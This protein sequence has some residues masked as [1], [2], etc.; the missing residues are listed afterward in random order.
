M[1]A[2]RAHVDSHLLGVLP[3]S[4]TAAWMTEH[5]WTKCGGCNRLLGANATSGWHRKCWADQQRARCG[6]AEE[7]N[8]ETE[9]LH[10]ELNAQDVDSL[11][12]ME[13][14]SLAAIRT[15]EH[16]PTEIA[17]TVETE[18]RRLVANVVLYNRPDAWEDGTMQDDAVQ[19]SRA[20]AKTAWL[21]LWMFPKTCLMEPQK[22]GSGHR[23]Q[24]RMICTLQNR[25]ERWQAGERSSLWEEA[26]TE[27]QDRMGQSSTKKRSD[28][29]IEKGKQ[30]QALKY[31]AMGMPAKAVRSLT[32]I[33]MAPADAHTEA[34]M[35]AKFPA[36]EAL[37]ADYELDSAPQSN[38]VTGEAVRNAVASMARGTA[39][40]PS[41]LRPDVIKQMLEKGSS[42]NTLGVMT[43]FVNLLLD[44]RAPRA[45]APWLAG[46][47]GYAFQKR[48]KRTAQD[49]GA[50]EGRL[51]VRP[52]C[53]GE[54]WRRIACKAILSTEKETIAQFLAPWQLAVGVK[55]G[56][57]AAVHAARE[58]ATDN[59]EDPQAVIL[60]FD[61]TNA[62][63]MVHRT[64]FLKRMHAVCPGMSRWLRWIYPYDEETW[65]VWDGNKIASETGGQQGCPLMGLCHASPRALVWR[66]CGLEPNTSYRSWTRRRQSA[67]WSCSPTTAWWEE[68]SSRWPGWRN[69]FQHTCRTRQAYPSENCRRYRCAHNIEWMVIA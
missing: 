9:E 15:I 8:A 53:C 21:E 25:L 13:E 64:V 62:Y 2:L 58:W 35:R 61:E 17:S 65:V 12:S 42:S 52:V 26:R 28:K 32:S 63:N 56:A 54:A 16:V 31:A 10:A 46:A 69:I 30:Q 4:P 66:C 40:G 39:A 68:D 48:A 57:E 5:K 36:R 41:G 19:A 33:G 20:R 49:E 38:E 24:R 7:G 14:I 47:A 55:G 37:P 43:L 51:G 60:D 50:T 27:H 1:A 22:G 59:K 18:Y 67:C 11:P 34:T 45:V 29:D 23:R 3:G 6:E 44:G